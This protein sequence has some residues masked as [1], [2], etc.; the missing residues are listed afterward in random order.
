MQYE[1]NLKGLEAYQ[2]EFLNADLFYMQAF[3]KH[4]LIKQ[5]YDI[6]KNKNASIKAV[7][8]LRKY[9]TFADLS[10][11]SLTDGLEIL[12]KTEIINFKLDHKEQESTVYLDV[13]DF[14]FNVIDELRK[15]Y[16]NMIKIGMNEAEFRKNLERNIRE[17]YTKH[18]ELKTK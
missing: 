2:K 4:E 18:Y 13:N 10:M 14:Y 15:Q 5:F 3:I 1:I 11:K 9:S 17:T 7:N 16:R 8:M 6:K 12:T